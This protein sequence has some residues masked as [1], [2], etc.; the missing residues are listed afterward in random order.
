M[1]SILVFVSD[2]YLNVY[3]S[4]GSVL[5]DFIMDNVECTGS[6]SNILQ[7]THLTNHNCGSSE[8]AGVICTGNK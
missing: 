8:G 5:A 2:L 6:E 4:Y 1:F 7:C 3:F